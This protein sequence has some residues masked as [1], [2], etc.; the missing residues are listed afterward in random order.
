M[1][2]FGKVAV[3]LGLLV[4][5]SCGGESDDGDG[6]AGG[7][8][9]GGTELDT[10]LPESTPLQDVTPE[11]YASACEA[12][13]EDVASRLGPDRTSRGV[14]EVYGAA[15]T[16]DP[17][18]CQSA[19]DACEEDLD[20]GPH[21]LLMISRADLDFTRF[22]CGDTGEL[23]NCTVTVGEF[24][25]CLQ[26]QMA[27]FEAAIADNDCDAAA[28]VGITEATGFIDSLGSPPPSCTRVQDEC[29]GVGPFGD[30][31]TP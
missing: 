24:E 9:G 27:A 31:G 25:T 7:G 11:Q 13:R 1:R 23:Q 20:P 12:L 2:H 15:L 26:D 21:P 14:C 22:E 17:A 5:S 18:S 19:A 6:P 30:L 4:A 28:S 16:D 3:V 29:P 10:G 8:G